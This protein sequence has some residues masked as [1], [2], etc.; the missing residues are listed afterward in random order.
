M[1]NDASPELFA[2]DD[3]CAAAIGRMGAID[4][5][6]QRI[7]A[8]K[9]QA[10]ATAS[11][12]A[13]NQAKPLQEERGALEA[14]VAAYCAA[15]RDRLTAGRTRQFAPFATG[16]GLWRKGKDKVVVDETKLDKI[17]AKLRELKLIRFI[18]TP[19][20]EIDKTAI[21]KEPAAIKPVRGI[22]IEPGKETFSVEPIAADLVER[23]A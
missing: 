15:N 6:L 23:P 10:V 2:D 16:K 13:E 19:D 18:R 8:A 3:A 5:S 17:I 4:V 20:P 12:N 9:S 22:S 1:A 7:A 21:A 11:V 14:K